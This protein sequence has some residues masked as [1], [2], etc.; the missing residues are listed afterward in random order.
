MQ[1]AIIP[2]LNAPAPDPGFI[3]ID[4]MFGAPKPVVSGSD[5]HPLRAEFTAPQFSCVLE[6]TRAIETVIGE[7]IKLV[8]QPGIPGT[9]WELARRPAASK[10]T[11][12]GARLIADVPGCYIVAITLPG[13]WRRDVLIAA[14]PADIGDALV[15]PSS[16]GLERRMRLRAIV[17]EPTVTRETIAAG[18]EGPAIDLATLAGFGGK[19]RSAFDVTRFR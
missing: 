5:L 17:S 4:S 11:M 18:L 6:H 13:G 9:A 15:Y 1:S 12:D 7:S 3:G 8:T 16:M 14:F 19:K 2:N 10:A